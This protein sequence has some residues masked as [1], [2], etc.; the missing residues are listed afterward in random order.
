MTQASQA[1]H[2]SVTPCAGNVWFPQSTGLDLRESFS[3]CRKVP[4]RAWSQ[5]GCSRHS[6]ANDR[7]SFPEGGHALRN[8]VTSVE[9]TLLEAEQTVGNMWV[10]GSGPS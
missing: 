9:E 4:V 7:P 6:G 3:G 1:G 2:W 5:P 8:D 10:P